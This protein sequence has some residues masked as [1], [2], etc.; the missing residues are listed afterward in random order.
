MRCG[1]GPGFEDDKM[2]VMQNSA[3]A[4]TDEEA[5]AIC[6][7]LECVGDPGQQ[8]WDYRW[9]FEGPSPPPSEE[10]APAQPSEEDL[11]QIRVALSSL[12]RRR[13]F[14]ERHYQELA[15][16]HPEQ[17][18]AVLDGAPVASAP[19]LAGVVD[20]LS[21]IGIDPQETYIEF[22]TLNPRPRLL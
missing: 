21:E 9:G 8:P 1:C 11:R 13:E 3:R 12:E 14:W 22:M 6:A 5:R 10:P 20:R 7:A 18:V 4:A 15:E 19:S 17:F 2:T 16:Q